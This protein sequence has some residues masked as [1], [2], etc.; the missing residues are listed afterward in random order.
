MSGVARM[1]ATSR[2]PRAALAVEILA[3]AELCRG[4]VSALEALAENAGNYE[5]STLRREAHGLVRA[6]F[7]EVSGQVTL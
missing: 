6:L 3:I 1:L 7:A 5:P 4:A 2:F